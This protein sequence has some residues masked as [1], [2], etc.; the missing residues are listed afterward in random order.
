MWDPVRGNIWY[1]VDSLAENKTLL[2]K[3]Y[4]YPMSKQSC[5]VIGVE[6]VFNSLCSIYG[7]LFNSANAHCDF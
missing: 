3:D 1:T 7:T 4:V 5:V 6:G 2:G